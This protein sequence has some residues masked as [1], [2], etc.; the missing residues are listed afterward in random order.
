MDILNSEEGQVTAA[1]SG[2]EAGKLFKNEPGKH[3]VQRIPPTE[4]NGRKQT[5]TIS[6]SVLPFSEQTNLVIPDKDLK[7]E[8]INL[9]G[10]GGQRRNRTMSDSRITHI[11]TGIQ[12][13]ISGRKYHQ[14]YHEALKL[15]TERVNDKIRQ[16]S[17]AAGSEARRG[18]MGGGT[19]SDKR[20]TYNF[21]ESRCVDHLLN[22]KTSNIKAVMKGDFSFLIK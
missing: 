6:V 10:P 13:T 7:V 11:P 3:C 15:V 5:S 20:R 12:A 17:L 9:G 8:A 18:Q 1:I 21:M 16:E 2:K 19:R 4:H 14:N 22:K